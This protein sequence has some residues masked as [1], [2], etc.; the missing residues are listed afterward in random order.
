MGRPQ[1]LISI[2][3]ALFILVL[4]PDSASAQA[5]TSSWITI[6][7][8]GTGTGNGTVQYTYTANP[9]PAARTGTIMIAGQAFT[10][11]QAGNLTAVARVRDFRGLGRSDVLLYDRVSGQEYTALSN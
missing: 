8:G 7:S 3:L 6:T 2:A 4:L 10:V 1:H 11:V 5:G 9:G